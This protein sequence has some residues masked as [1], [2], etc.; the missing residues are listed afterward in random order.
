MR[1]SLEILGLIGLGL[2]VWLT[3]SALWGPQRLPARV[4]THFDAAGNPNAWGSPTGMLLLPAIAIGV[5][6]LMTVVAQF[7]EAFHYSVRTTAANLPR[8]Q[9][10]TL[11]MLAWIK[12]EIV[13]LFAVLQ[14]AFV[15]SAQTGDGRLFPKILPVFLVLIFGTVAAHMIALMRAA[16]DA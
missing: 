1:K 14:W 16:R 5:Y 8:L 15:R 11:D 3:W 13:C 7:P 6:L 4:P 2:L 9:A 10:V 12:A